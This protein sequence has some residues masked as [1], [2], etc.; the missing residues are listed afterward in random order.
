[1]PRNDAAAPSH[2]CSGIRIQAIDV[3]QSLGIRHLGITDMDNHRGGGTLRRRRTPVGK[4]ARK[5]CVV[6]SYST[7]APADHHEVA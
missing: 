2:A 6:I 3:V 5:Q 1:M 4:L 7:V